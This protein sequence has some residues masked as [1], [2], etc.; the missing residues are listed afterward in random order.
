MNDD[1]DALMKAGRRKPLWSP[2]ATTQTVCYKR[3]AI[4]Q[5]IPHREPMLLLDEI[6][7][8]DL[9]Q[10]GARDHR[11]IAEDDPIFAGHFPDEPIYPGAFLVETMGQL[12]L[13]LMY[14]CEHQAITIK[15]GQAPRRPRLLKVH[16][17]SFMAEV[18]PG[19]DLTILAKLID[20]N[21]FT[22]IGAGQIFKGDTVCALA[23]ME[24]YLAS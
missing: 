7:E 23:I 18:L 15:A 5:L 8:I 14:F 1:F 21:E 13:S 12:G 20:M 9:A 6:S 11:H 10:N 3:D 24:V 19:D 16:R 2:A 22:V 17:A 4:E